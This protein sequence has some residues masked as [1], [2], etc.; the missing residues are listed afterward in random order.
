MDEARDPTSTKGELCRVAC[1]GGEARR[2]AAWLAIT[3]D[4][5]GEEGMRRGFHQAF[6]TYFLVVWMKGKCGSEQLMRCVME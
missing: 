6:P 3:G 4:Y 1:V 5:E 2:C